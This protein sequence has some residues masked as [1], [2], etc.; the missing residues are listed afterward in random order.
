MVALAAHAR[1]V[2]G[3]APGGR[4]GRP[5]DHRRTPGNTHGPPAPPAPLE[6]GPA[7]GIRGGGV[8]QRKKAQLQKAQARAEKAAGQEEEGRVA[9]V[10]RV[11][12][13]PPPREIS[14]V[15]V[16]GVATWPK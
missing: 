13:P 1:P 9:P 16:K 3:R 15:T 5:E 6:G 11:H 12:C 2:S 10:A 8:R 7:Q 14:E 4:A